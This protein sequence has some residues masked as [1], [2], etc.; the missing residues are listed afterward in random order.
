MNF[1]IATSFQGSLVK[2]DST[3]QNAV[4]TTVFDLQMNPESPGLRFHKL[5]VAKDKN[6]CSV[7]VNKDIRIIVHK[8]DDNLLVC[9]VDHHDKAY[10]WV[11][12]RKLT[13]HPSTGAAQIIEVRERIEEIFIPTYVEA[14]PIP[15][16]KPLLFKDVPDEELLGYGVP[17]EWIDAVRL[18][19]EDTLLDLADSLPDEASEALLELAV[20]GKPAPAPVVAPG[21]DPFD[22]PDAQRRFRVMSN[23]DELKA[24]LEFPWDTWAIFLHPD[25]RQLVERDFNGAARASGSAGTGKTVVALHR[26]AFLA[27]NN[28][29]ARILLTTFSETLAYALQIKL[30]RLVC[31]E[32]ML[33]ERLEVHSIES[34]GKRLYEINVGK[35]NLA[36]R[37]DIEPLLE[38]ASGSVGSH[39]F[40]MSFLWTEWASVVDAWQLKTWEE[41]RDVRRLGRKTRLAEPQRKILWEIFEKVRSE[42]RA[43]KMVTMADVYA[44]VTRHIETAKQ[45][46]FEFAVVDEAQDIGVPE[47][48]FLSAVGGN[49]P[50]SLFFGGDLGQRIFQQPFS[51]KALGVDVR[52]RSHTLRINYR[53]SHQIR[54]QADLL[55]PPELKDVDGITEERK[56]TVSVF[57]GPE[58]IVH[59]ADDEGAEVASVSEW[60]KKCQAEGIL[61]NEIGVFVRSEAELERAE[62]AVAGSSMKYHMLNEKMESA[63]NSVSISTMH[64]AKGLEFRA[65]VVMACDDEVV[66]LQSRIETVTDDSDLEDVYNTERHLLYVAC[67]RARDRLMVSGLDPCSEFLDDLKLQEG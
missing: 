59:I 53:T 28:P 67:T 1:Y 24:A 40:S 16:Q 52:G 36:T 49:R 29:D 12:N 45:P 14:E 41:Y 43:M 3:N 8:S 61:P 10:Q 20:G 65:V 25:Q 57:N 7:S 32:P 23:L 4:K 21:A 46:P 6:F 19:N 35:L 39:K 54:R 60:L 37:L 11:K 31:S 15:I 5:T 34:I 38:N 27:R 48:R 44:D 18:V 62:T 50:N 22:H 2:L 58:P 63:P 42:L 56:G 26:A 30:R 9:Y 51:W 33:A 17:P 13:T 55:L 47:L 64:L 66:P